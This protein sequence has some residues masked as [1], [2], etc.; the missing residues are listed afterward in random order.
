MF[1]V[2]DGDRSLQFIGNLLAKSSSERPGAFRW[3]EFELY[4]TESGSYILSRVGVS[5]IFHGAACALVSRYKLK[6]KPN[7]ELS[8]AATPCEECG[9]DSSLDLVFPEKFR[10]WAQVSST[11]E[12]VLEALYKESK[13]GVWY[14]TSVAQR[15][16]EGAAKVDFG[17]SEVY[18]FEV[19]P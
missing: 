8:P 10:Y 6:E 18:N 3:I 4:K 9:P 12:G 15:L 19:I 14:L 11:P 7:Y 2:R 16:L 13:D 5:L 17:I 1:S